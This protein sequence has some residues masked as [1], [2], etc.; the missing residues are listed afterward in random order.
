MLAD[1]FKNRILCDNENKQYR[2]DVNTKKI[3]RACRKYYNEKLD[4]KFRMKLNRKKIARHIS[5][6]QKQDENIQSQYRFID[7]TDAYVE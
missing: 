5:R 6:S 2:L 7:Y 3:L 4:F 1:I